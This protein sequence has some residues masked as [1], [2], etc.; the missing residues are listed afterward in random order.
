MSM[1]IYLR[2][3][4]KY[5]LIDHESRLRI[6]SREYLEAHLK[7]PCHLDLDFDVHLNLKNRLILKRDLKMTL[8]APITILIWPQNVHK[9]IQGSPILGS[10]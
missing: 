5:E 7:L 8:V 6:I 10:L 1:P 2:N 3:A 9:S 4:S